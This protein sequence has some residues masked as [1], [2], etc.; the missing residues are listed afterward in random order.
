MLD[1]LRTISI[2]R[3]TVMAS[4]GYSC[5]FVEAVPK[6]LQTECSICLHTV[7]DPY[8]VDCCGYRFCKDCIIPIATYNKKCPLCNCTFSSVIHDKLLHRTLNE[9]LV[10]CT[11][12]DGGCDWTGTLFALDQHLNAMP[13]SLEKRMEG[14]S[15]QT[16]RCNHCGDDFKRYNLLEHE[17]NCPRRPIICIHCEV[18]SS[19]EAELEEH[20][21]DCESFPVQCENKCGCTVKREKMGEHL[22]DYCPLEVVKCEY[23]YAGCDVTLPRKEMTAHVDNAAKDHL[24]LVTKKLTRQEEELKELAQI[25]RRF[26]LVQRELMQ[27]DAD[28]E[29]ERAQNDNQNKMMNLFKRLC[30]LR[31]ADGDP[32]KQVLVTNIDFCEQEHVLKSLFGQFG[33]IRRIETY[34]M[35]WSGRVA[36][37]EYVENSSVNNLFCK[38][39]TAGVKLRKVSLNCARLSYTM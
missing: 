17:L 26:E 10:Y 9:K 31:D 13:D 16:L 24:H 3:Q 30:D 25:R 23:F 2:E 34:T 22:N 19:P 32:N 5:Q 33:R 28:L 39:N 6:E 18:F 35:S 36:V 29:K 15:V 14:C 7:R 4:G 27:K 1:A 11:H 38:Y 21:K 20:W 37:V 12:K 8:M